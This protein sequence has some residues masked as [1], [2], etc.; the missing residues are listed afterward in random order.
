MNRLFRNIRIY[1]SGTEP[2]FSLE[3]RLFNLTSLF[4]T[5]FAIIAAVLNTILGLETQ[6][7]WLSVIGAIIS[8]VLFYLARFRHFFSITLIFCY[9][10]TTALILGSM[11]FYNNGMHGTT[12]YVYM[13]L[14]NVFVLIMPQQYQ[15]WVFGILY[16][17]VAVLLSAEYFNPGWIIPYH[18]RE[19]KVL[20]HASG[21][22]Y[23][24]FFTTAIIVAS[25]RSFYQERQKVMQQNVALTILNEQ[26]EAQ[27]KVLE[28]SVQ[29]AN[30]R[31]DNI[32]VLMNELNHRVKN[33]LQV[34]SSLLKLQAQTITD[35]KARQAILDSRNR[36]KSMVLVHQQL[37]LDENA[38]QIFMPEYLRNLSQSLMHTYKGA[39]EKEIVTFAVSPVWLKVEK[40]IPVG[41]ISNELITNCFKH[42]N[43]IDTDCKIEVKLT[44]TGDSHLLSVSDN[45]TGFTEAN[46]PKTFGLG[47]VKSLVTQ[48][49]GTYQIKFDKGTCW[50][51][52]FN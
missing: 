5:V 37:Y 2:E 49:N 6:T 20:D 3:H 10:V 24:M 28:D 34:V 52:Y 50:E 40:A 36:L 19:E 41:L 25:R 16:A 48:L 35:E 18:S 39:S 38:Q 32:E 47:L 17:S 8:L 22:F 7:I 31:R 51:I 23:S 42:A 12:I 45:G 46:K 30:L 43:N 44:K 4:I 33:N 15:Y 11:Y 13:M 29:L 21:L 9:V 27:R 14:L 26:I 1:F